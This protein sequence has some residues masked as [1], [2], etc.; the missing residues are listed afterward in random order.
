MMHKKI[1][2]LKNKQKKKLKSVGL[3]HQSHDMGH[4]IEITIKTANN[5]K[6]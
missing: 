5:N 6:L 4:D 1:Y 3:T 2:Q